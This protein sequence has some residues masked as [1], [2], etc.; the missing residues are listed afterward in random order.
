M[1]HVCILGLCCVL[2]CGQRGDQGVLFV[3]YLVDTHDD[4]TCVFPFPS[5]P[6]LETVPYRDTIP[7]AKTRKEC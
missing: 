7:V 1:A 6:T 5:A 2:L 4:P 3:S